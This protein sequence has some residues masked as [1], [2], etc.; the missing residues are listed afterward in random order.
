[1]TWAEFPVNPARKTL[2]QFAA[3]WLIFFIAMALHRWLFRGQA[4][5]ATYLAVLSVAVGVPG[6]IWPRILRWLYVTL[7]VFAFPIGWVVTQI[8]LVL[9]FFGII[10]PIAW[11][12]RISGRDVLHRKPDPTRETWWQP[13]KPVTDLRR[14]FRQY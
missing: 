3:A 5:L 6:L 13:R 11:I 2:R 14:Y 8:A 4:H 10:T 9:I 12:M 7:M 1:M